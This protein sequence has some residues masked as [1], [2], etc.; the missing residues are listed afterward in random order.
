MQ[1]LCQPADLR[2]SSTRR[3]RLS[4]RCAIE[5]SS[6]DD[7]LARRVTAAV[8]APA[9][10]S[11]ISV[12]NAS[13]SASLLLMPSRSAHAEKHPGHRS[14]PCPWRTWCCRPTTSSLPH[15]WPGCVTLL[16]GHECVS[17]EERD[18]AIGVRLAAVR[19]LLDTRTPFVLIADLYCDD[20]CLKLGVIGDADAVTDPRLDVL[21][22]VEVALGDE[23][24]EQG[25]ADVLVDVSM[26]SSLASSGNLRIRRRIAIFWLAEGSASI[27][28][29]ATT[30]AGRTSC[31]W[32]PPPE[33]FCQA[34]A[35]T[36]TRPMTRPSAM[37]M[38]RNR[39]RL[40]F[41]GSVA[42]WSL[43]SWGSFAG[44]NRGYR[45]AR[46]RFGV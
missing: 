8:D 44:R 45:T 3:I 10:A 15:R 22:V 12:P 31:G 23:V 39:L 19:Q 9:K 2:D 32:A 4:S 14:H 42:A 21:V 34:N 38:M 26:P 41:A 28:A 17:I 6:R 40:L 30:V 37:P 25:L 16:L 5:A 13:S 11:C 43:Q 35:P 46:M 1:V 36:P 33:S 29:Y 27:R 18:T 24:L 20:R 7:E